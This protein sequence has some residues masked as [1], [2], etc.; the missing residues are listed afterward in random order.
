MESVRFSLQRDERSL[1]TGRPA[2]G[3]ILRGSDAFL[4]PFSLMWCAFAIF[5]ESSVLRTGGPLLL[6]LWGIPFVAV[7]LY[8]V[9]GRFF[10]D[11]WARSRTFYALTHE[12]ALIRSGIFSN[13]TVALDLLVIPDIGLDVRSDGRGT[14]TFG[15]S[16][17]A[18]AMNNAFPIARNRQQA[19]PMFE[20]IDDAQAVY[21]LIMKV[22][23]ERGR[24]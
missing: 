24:P 7:G 9:I 16:P 12:R 10:I 2:Q 8:M 11:A 3:L 20:R 14:I 15:T 13:R 1:W 23:H 4:I 22:K 18:N 21:N 6:K 17:G 19:A 5:W